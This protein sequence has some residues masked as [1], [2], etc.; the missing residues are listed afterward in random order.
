LNS[1]PVLFPEIEPRITGA[2]QLDD[3]HTMYWEELGNPSGIPLVFL[4][5]GPGAGTPLAYRRHFDPEYYRIIMY[6]QRG[7]GRSTPTGE[8]RNNTTQ[9]LIADLETLRRH[10]G[11]DRWV[12][13]GASWGTTLAL[14]YGVRHADNCLGF[15]LRGIFLGSPQE[16]D[17]FLYGMRNIFPEAWR[18][19]ANH[20]SAGE[21]SDLLSAYYRRL[22]SQDRAAQMAAARSW[23]MYEG[24]CSS[25]LPQP[26]VADFFSEPRLALGLGVIES[27]YFVNR[28]FLEADEILR[29]L[30]AIGGK[31]AI[32][33]QGRYDIIC[34]IVTAYRL[35]EDWPN[36]QLDV[37]PD[38][39]HSG[40]D[41]AIARAQIRAGDRMKNM[42][43]QGF[44][45]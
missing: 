6:D 32:I 28:A 13:S 37:I 25:L 27:H 33:V 20:V 9:H 45:A 11:I 34:P 8:L 5:G 26:D 14:A 24:L 16:I 30:R 38:G 44:S 19:F 22:T 29:N 36:A 39:G 3:I 41:P 35:A 43:S 40:M 31:P 42:L 23:S 12:V 18:E 4:H 17:W 1:E 7:A 21:R 10:L 15:L 2:I